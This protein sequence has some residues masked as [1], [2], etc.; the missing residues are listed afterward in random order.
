MTGD[1]TGP[2]RDDAAMDWDGEE[3]QERFD[4]L[5][6]AGKDVHGEADFVCA[7]SPSSVLDAGCGSG[8]VARELLRRGIDVVGVDAD[9]SM[10]AAARSRSPEISWVVADLGVL[11]LDRRFDVVLMAGNVPLFT[12]P[13][14]Q[15]ALV[16]GCAQHVNGGGSLV[17]G[18]QLDRGYDL[19]AY[20]EHC[21]AAGLE[22]SARWST[23]AQD[24]FTDDGAYAVSVHRC[25]G[26][27]T[28]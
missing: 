3:Y 14:T 12:T 22:L 18:F 16:A 24:A 1:L 2:F 19:D 13:G 11:A 27:S 4:E 25:G 8:R 15:A 5:A 6:A 28:R 26:S 17:S 23:W 9:A 7:M 10:I 21:R 20:D